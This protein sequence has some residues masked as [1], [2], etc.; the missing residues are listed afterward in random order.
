MPLDPHFTQSVPSVIA[1]Q[2]ASEISVYLVEKIYNSDLERRNKYEKATQ[3]Y[4]EMN[5]SVNTFANDPD[6]TTYHIKNEP[7]YASLSRNLYEK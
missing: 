4:I 5:T 1:R 2:S 7:D 3:K 6:N